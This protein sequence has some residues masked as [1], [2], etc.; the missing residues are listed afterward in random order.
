MELNQ[1][2]DEEERVVDVTAV[3]NALRKEMDENERLKREDP[4]AFEAKV[5]AGLPLNWCMMCRVEFRGYGNN[6]RPVLDGVVCDECNAA[7]LRERL[8]AHS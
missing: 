4:A 7:V 2:S 6:A 3:L 1:D 5:R 8:R